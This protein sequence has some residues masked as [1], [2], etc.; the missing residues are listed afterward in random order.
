MYLHLLL[1]PLV[2]DPLI[3]QLLQ[4]PLQHIPG[5]APLL[6]LV[7]QR[8]AGVHLVEDAAPE[9]LLGSLDGHVGVCGLDLPEPHCRAE[10]EAWG[11]WDTETWSV[12]GRAERGRALPWAAEQGGGGCRT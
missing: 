9:L 3:Q 5:L 6:D 12:P 10:P 1:E 8:I 11:C 7:Q 2:S 4:P